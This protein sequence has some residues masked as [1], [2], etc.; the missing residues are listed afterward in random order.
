MNSTYIY[1]YPVVYIGSFAQLRM[2]IKQYLVI[3]DTESDVT[4]L[5]K[6]LDKF[7]LCQLAAVATTVE[8]AIEILHQKPIDLIFLDIQLTSQSGL[9]L[10][11]SGVALPP[12]IIISAYPEYAIESYEIGKAADYL[13]KPFTFERLHIAI[14]RALQL[15]Q[16]TNSLVEPDAIF[17]KMGRK[18]QRFDFQAIDYAEAF[19]IYSK[20]YVGDQINL[21]NERLSA[22]TRLLPSQLFMRVHKS[23]LINISKI[24]SYDRHNLWLGKTKIPIGISFRPQLEGLLALFDTS[25]E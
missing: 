10:L 1:P 14:T 19:G 9:A 18:I 13:L 24:T 4:Y 17:L 11:K 8:A 21:V 7:A 16:T 2:K 23:Y 20:L 22:L 25:S 6:Y 12:V 15:Q 3:D 5:K